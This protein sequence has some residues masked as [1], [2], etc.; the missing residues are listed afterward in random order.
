MQQDALY[1]NQNGIL[2]IA[3]INH[4]N[5]G[6]KNRNKNRRY[7][8]KTKNKLNSRL[9]HNISIIALS[10]DILNLPIKRGCTK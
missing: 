1:I 6:K 9:T 7:K 10:V 2:K 4:S 5:I 8:Q 3:H